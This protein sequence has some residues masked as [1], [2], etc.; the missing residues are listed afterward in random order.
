[1]VAEDAGDADVGAERAL[2][3]DIWA[4][5]LEVGVEAVEPSTI[6]DPGIYGGAPGIWVDKSRTG[7]LT[8]D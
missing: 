2:R 5:L 8:P 3:N 7:E 1:M 4:Q 6:R